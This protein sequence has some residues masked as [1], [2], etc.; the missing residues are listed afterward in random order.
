MGM[1]DRI[2]C[3]V[4][5]PDTNKIS[6]NEF[7]TKSLDNLLNKYEI[8]EDGTLW[9]E[10]YESTYV[11]DATHF[12]GGYFSTIEGSI[13]WTQVSDVHQDIIFYFMD[14]D[15]KWHDYIA[16]FTNGKLQSLLVREDSPW[17]N[18]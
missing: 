9:I 16:R 11:P 8:R 14:D 1:F 4:P 18:Q 5:L 7:Q 13:K 6:E 12:L 3:K 10:S 2:V 17:K 15:R